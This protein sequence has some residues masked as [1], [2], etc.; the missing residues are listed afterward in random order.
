M[1]FLQTLLG[2]LFLKWKLRKSITICIST[3]NF[4]IS[5][6]AEVQYSSEYFKKELERV[7]QHEKYAMKTATYEIDSSK[8]IIVSNRKKFNFDTLVAFKIAEKLRKTDVIAY[9]TL[10]ERIYATDEH[11]E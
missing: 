11:R 10:I 8:K 3:C 4:N 7:T 5:I 6:L 1:R 9:L 2:L